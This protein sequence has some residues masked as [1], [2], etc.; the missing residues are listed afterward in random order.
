L[1]IKNKDV[2]T[3]TLLVNPAGF[4][5]LCAQCASFMVTPDDKPVTKYIQST[6]LKPL[7]GFVTQK[8]IDQ[9]TAKWK[10]LSE[11][12]TADIEKQ[13]NEALNGLTDEEKKFTA[14]Y[15]PRSSYKPNPDPAQVVLDSIEGIS[16][17]QAENK[18]AKWMKDQR[19]LD[20]IAKYGA[21]PY[22]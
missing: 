13:R 5:F 16:V 9:Y 10:P 22:K 20:N 3:E 14:A 1:G 17:K 7:D 6:V 4:W 21:I 15:S 19:I 11:V 2:G 8:D 12:A 18:A